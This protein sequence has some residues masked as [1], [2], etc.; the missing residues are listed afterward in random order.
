MLKKVRREPEQETAKRVTEEN[1]K[2]RIV[3]GH[4][5]YVRKDSDTNPEWQCPCCQS[6]Y[7]K[8]NK[9]TK[10]LSPKELRK[11]NKIYLEEKDSLGMETKDE[12]IK[13]GVGLTGILFLQGM[14]ISLCKLISTPN[15]WVVGTVIAIG[16]LIY[17]FSSYFT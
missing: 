14:G 13:T 10:T 16:S 12:L 6:A 4:C 1:S 11:R 2:S 17:Y 5:L 3:C 8:V 15:F 7:A 9:K